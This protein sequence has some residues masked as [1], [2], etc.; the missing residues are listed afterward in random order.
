MAFSWNMYVNL[1]QKFDKNK[2]IELEGYSNYVALSY[3]GM[4]KKGVVVANLFNNKHAL[5]LDNNL[6]YNAL[7]GLT[8]YEKNVKYIKAKKKPMSKKVENKYIIKYAELY[9]MDL[10][11]AT[12]ILE[13]MTTSELNNLKF[14]L[15]SI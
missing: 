7:K 2:H 8:P 10:K 11:D 9:C 13:D 15:D 4:C 14:T 1:Y 12:D 3:V 5:G 6:F